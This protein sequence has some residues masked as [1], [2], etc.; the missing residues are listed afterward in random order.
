M[1]DF[2]GIGQEEERADDWWLG[3]GKKNE[4]VRTEHSNL[5]KLNEIY[6]LSQSFDLS[7]TAAVTLNTWG[8]KGEA[9]IRCSRSELVNAYT[10]IVI[11][12]K[13]KN[14]ILFLKYI[15]EYRNKMLTHYQ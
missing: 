3:A 10:I 7:R 13:K 9:F 15:S 12:N 8:L 5:A 1:F 11:I 6:W 2:R 4:F 14:E